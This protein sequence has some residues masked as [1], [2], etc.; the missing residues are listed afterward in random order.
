MVSHNRCWLD[1]LTINWTDLSPSQVTSS[2]HTFRTKAF[3]CCCYST[4][5]CRHLMDA[6]A[7]WRYLNNL[8]ENVDGS[9]AA[10]AARRTLFWSERAHITQIG[11]WN[12]LSPTKRQPVKR[13]IENCV[14][15]SQV[16]TK[17]L[18]KSCNCVQLMQCHSS[19]VPVAIAGMPRRLPG[20]CIRLIFE[21][22]NSQIGE[23]W[24]NSDFTI[25]L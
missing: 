3:L 15:N 18:W 24:F 20:R 17:H 12:Y 23:S 14:E 22:C 16:D 10:T 13:S 25:F 6:D 7:F 4:T 9:A 8:V 1:V 2:A 21:L 19:A 5:T 11:A